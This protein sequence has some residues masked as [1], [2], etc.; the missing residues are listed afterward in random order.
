MGTNTDLLTL[1]YLEQGISAA[2][3]MYGP[4]DWNFTQNLL[5]YLRFFT[6]PKFISTGAVERINYIVSTGMGALGR[7]VATADLIGLNSL[8]GS[9][10]HTDSAMESV[11]EY[12]DD[13]LDYLD[14]YD[15][16]TYESGCMDPEAFNY[17]PTATISGYCT[18]KIFGCMDPEGHNYAPTANTDDGTCILYTLNSIPI[19]AN[20]VC[21][22]QDLPV[23]NRYD[24]SSDIT[25]D[26]IVA[27]TSGT[28]LYFDPD[29][30]GSLVNAGT[31]WVN[32]VLT[33]IQP[34]QY[35]C[36]EN[37]LASETIGLSNTSGGCV[38]IADNSL[39]EYPS[40]QYFDCSVLEAG[41][42]LS[43]LL[44]YQEAED[45]VL[46][47]ANGAAA[48]RGIVSTSVGN[49]II[50]SV[51]VENVLYTLLGISYKG[52]F[53][54]DLDGTL[55]EYSLVDGINRDNPLYFRNQLK[56]PV[57]NK[58]E[59]E[60]KN[61]MKLKASLDKIINFTN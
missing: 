60:A 3:N 1:L 41:E 22:E 9:L 4:V 32:S 20:Y 33:F 5:H 26:G 37:P 52:K 38:N 50:G 6:K 49:F 17:N 18:E 61:L 42:G 12:I 30:P 47:C 7:A 28:S 25:P 56:V 23:C 43:Q 40:V 39:C 31:P 19:H 34:Y 16:S 8:T 46:T 59:K 21:N 13:A 11:K 45:Y 54:K 53:I 24:N 48:S 14:A 35:S 36:A 51:L 58:T 57:N 55:Y 15:I 29:H 44:D 10:D 27:D 2:D